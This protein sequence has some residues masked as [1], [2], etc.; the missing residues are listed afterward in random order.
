[1]TC[2]TRL[3]LR[4]LPGRLDRGGRAGEDHH[5]HAGARG[6]GAAVADPRVHRLAVGRSDAAAVYDARMNEIREAIVAETA[7]WQPSS[8]VGT[9]PWDRDQEWT[10]EWR[11]LKETFFPQRTDRLLQ[12]LRAHSGWWTVL[13]P[14]ISPAPGGVPALEQAE[15]EFKDHSPTLRELL[16]VKPWAEL[17]KTATCTAAQRA[18]AISSK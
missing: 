12:Q 18:L 16:A 11:Y 10:N 6:D 7:R 2:T 5:A 14:T 17:P 3:L 8:T 9:L 13:P 4:W 1:M 15:K